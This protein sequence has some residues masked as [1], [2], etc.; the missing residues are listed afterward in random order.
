MRIAYRVYLVR[1]ASSQH[2]CTN[3]TSHAADA[4]VCR[5]ARC[6]GTEAPWTPD[7]PVETPPSVRLRDA[8][9]ALSAA[10][11]WPQWNGDAPGSHCLL[12][13]PGASLERIRWI[14]SHPAALAQCSHWLQASGIRARAVGDTAGAARSIATD[15][16]FTRAAIA[17]A[18]AAEIYGLA[19]IAREIADD[20]ENRTRF[21]IVRRHRAE[22][23]A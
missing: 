8:L 16:D 4:D 10:P 3:P 2:D 11:A 15:R 18:D 1:S 17:S 9:A 7:L 23:A 20:P 5:G 6:G 22:V 19:V 12:A 14:E 21:V 13:L